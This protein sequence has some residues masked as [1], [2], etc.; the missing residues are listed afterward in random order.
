MQVGRDLRKPVQ[1]VVE[2]SNVVCIGLDLKIV[3][4]RLYLAFGEDH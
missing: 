1:L 3:T 2:E 4:K